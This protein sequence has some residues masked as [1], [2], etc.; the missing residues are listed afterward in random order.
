[1]TT[2]IYEIVNLADGKASSY[3]GSSQDMG[4]RWRTHQ[5]AL[6]ANRHVNPHLQSA[7]NKYGEDAFAFSIL[8]EVGDDM[9][10]VMEQEYIDDYFDR[11]S[12]YNIAMR[13]GAPMKGR[14]HTEETK[15]RM[16]A[17]RSG[18]R[19]SM[20][21]KN[22]TEEARRKMSKA[23]K[24]IVPWNKGL[25]TGPLSEEHKRKLGEACTGERHPLWGKSHTAEARRKISEA[26]AKP[27]PAFIHRETG[28]IILAGMNLKA[29]C[30][31]RGFDQRHMWKVMRG[32]ANSHNGWVLL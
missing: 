23:K 19:A 5:N 8:E 21:G 4:A 24:G 30:D 22:H 20:Q 28:E 9:L 7:W 6:R 11:G 26:R 2:G 17:S 10:L 1:M 32:Q 13:A 3:V 16:S 14:K 18:G 27:Y 15:R 29:M 12:C 31:R 25:N